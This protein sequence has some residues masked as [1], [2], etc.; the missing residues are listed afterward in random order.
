[1]DP[2]TP[3]HFNAILVGTGLVESIV[4]AA[5]SKAGYSV[6]QLDQQSYY[7]D[8][9][10]SLSL[11]ELAEWAS[12]HP[13]AQCSPPSPPSHLL[14]TGQRFSLS[15][16]PTLLRA[17]GSAIDLLVRSKVASYLSFGLLNGIGLWSAEEGEGEVKG[18]GRVERVP[19]SKADVFNHPTLS[20]VEKR[21][22]T[23]LL[24]LAAGQD[25]FEEDQRLKD[26]SLT[27]QDFLQKE[28]KVS[29]AVA[30]SL[31]Y[32][33]T[34]CSSSEDL[35]IPALHRLRSFIHS[36]GRYG[37]SPFLVG[38]YGGAGD[39]VGG[40]SRICAVWGGGQI[41]GRP[42]E[43]LQLDSTPGIIV[44]P[45]QAPFL[46]H[47]TLP[48]PPSKPSTSSSD[49]EVKPLGI[50]VLI[51]SD[52]P[53]SV[54]T[55]DWVVA[56]PSHLPAL[57][58]TL[59]T[60]TEPPKSV[61]AIVI[62]PEPIPF[63]PPREATEEDYNEPDSNLFIF[64]PKA[65][66]ESVGTV[67]A[68]QVGPGTFAAPAG[69][70]VLYL[71]APLLSTPSPETDASTLLTPYLTSLLSLSSSSPPLEPLFTTSY[72]S[73]PPPLP[74]PPSHRTYSSSRP[75]LHSAKRR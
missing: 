74:P 18:K 4:A 24:L 13:S 60:S 66:E 32:A 59:P 41:L 40:F 57:F 67:T 35:A 36:I 6:L 52:K 48:P 31:A 21:R 10:A 73:H 47:D 22:L 12:S 62:L 23:K 46:V 30:N 68:L 15:L 34:L 39:L 14:P 17:N 45:S 29:P 7:G 43:A 44:P 28:V 8:T 56:S 55:A 51:E 71:S 37:P 70:Y 20:L 65:L 11:Q 42:I 26:P 53:S 61:H 75:S 69:S 49:S 2:D 33:L 19:A 38:H 58:P 5:L 64:P 25:A 3:T 1:M 63:P 72:F 50:P 27:F 9:W 54:F 16:L